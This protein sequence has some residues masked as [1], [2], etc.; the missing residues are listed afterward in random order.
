MILISGHDS[1]AMLDKS[2]TFDR[3]IKGG[4]LEEVQANVKVS[5]NSSTPIVLHRG[6]NH[7]TFL[8]G[9]AKSLYVGY[10]KVLFA[11]DTN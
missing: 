9:L 1:N 8:A 7:T 4:E 3:E 10:L 11:G 6:R 2:R 5:P